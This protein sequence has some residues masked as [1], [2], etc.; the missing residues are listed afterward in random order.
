MEMRELGAGGGKGDL[1]PKHEL[2][3]GD[4]QLIGQMLEASESK[5]NG[6]PDKL[7]GMWKTVSAAMANGTQAIKL[8]VPALGLNNGT[9]SQS[10]DY[11]VL[12]DLPLHKLLPALAGWLQRDKQ[13]GE[14]VEETNAPE[15]KKSDALRPNNALPKQIVSQMPPTTIPDLLLTNQ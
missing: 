6:Q 15:S 5:L 2:E 12:E 1:N 11:D 14:V 8:D 4:A 3:F 10:E 9:G 7:S 13:A